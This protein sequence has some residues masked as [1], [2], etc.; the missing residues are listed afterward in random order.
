MYYSPFNRL[1]LK[2][3]VDSFIRRQ[4]K[5]HFLTQKEENLLHLRRFLISEH[6]NTLRWYTNM[7]HY[8]SMKTRLNGGSKSFSSRAYNQQFAGTF[9]KIRTG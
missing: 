4:P 5:T 7:E 3:D 1:L 8:R 2:L 6:Y 9:K